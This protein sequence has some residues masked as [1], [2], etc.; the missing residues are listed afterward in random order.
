MRGSPERDARFTRVTF[1]VQRDVLEDFD[2]LAVKC[3]ATCRS[4]FI[5][6]ALSFAAYWMHAEELRQRAQE[7][8]L[9]PDEKHERVAWTTELGDAARGLRPDPSVQSAADAAQATYHESLT[10]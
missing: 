6:R 7:R 3:G 10:M 5:R 1:E 2:D 8:P 9:T 4:D